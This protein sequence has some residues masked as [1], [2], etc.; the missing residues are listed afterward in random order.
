MPLGLE[1]VVAYAFSVIGALL[2]LLTSLV[3]YV[4]LSLRR[5]V[6]DL[7]AEVQELRMV[8]VKLMHREDCRQAM[9]TV[10][11]RLNTNDREVHN[12]QE[13]MAR[14][15]TKLNIGEPKCPC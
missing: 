8:R 9:Q 15:E 5:D 12:L 11:G 3:V 10:Y 1:T 6:R 4:F 2:L 13:R 14:V 7:A